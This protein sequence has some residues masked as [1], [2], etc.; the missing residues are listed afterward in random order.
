MGDL[1]LVCAGKPIPGTRGQIRR[2]CGLPWSGGEAETWAYEYFDSVPT[3]PW[4]DLPGPPDLLAA[5]ALHPGFGR[6][7]ASYFNSGGGAEACQAWLTTLPRDTDLAD[8]EEPVVNQLA[9]LPQIAT[10][11]GLSVVSKVTH[12]KRPRLVPL[13]DRAIVDWY[14]PV[15][16]LRG[17]AAWPALIR[18]LRADLAEPPNREFLAD[19]RA[20]LAGEL[21][22]PV[23][24]DLRLV[25]IAIW[26][27]GRE[28]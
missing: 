25:D 19:V 1:T 3:N 2:Y 4:D 10:G 16:G 15:T 20:E 24:S 12:H 18:A 9:E 23:P 6:S 11:V 8:A 5:A 27:H 17:E 7:E 13:F 21:E 22:G 28:G 26:M 14:R